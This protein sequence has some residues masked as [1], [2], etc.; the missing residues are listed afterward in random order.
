MKNM[1]ETT[2]R[3]DLHGYKI[4]FILGSREEIARELNR[5]PHTIKKGG[6]S[7]KL[8][9]VYINLG[10]RSLIDILGTMTHEISHVVDILA[11]R[12]G[13]MEESEHKAYIHGYLFREACKGLG[14]G[15]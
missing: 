6:T 5:D 15:E 10:N 11:K 2:V 3:L 8:G 14:L 1:K 13:F 12:R 9:I 4:R 7:P